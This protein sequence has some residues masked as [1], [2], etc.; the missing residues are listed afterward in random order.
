MP[1]LLVDNVIAES[2]GCLSQLLEKFSRARIWQELLYLLL[3]C[4]DYSAGVIHLYHEKNMGK[5]GEM[6][7]T[8]PFESHCIM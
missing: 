2:F 7:Y 3:H 8:M 4:V 5:G 6:K 1:V